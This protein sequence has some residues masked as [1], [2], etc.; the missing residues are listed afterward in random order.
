M[1]TQDI[2]TQ[3]RGGMSYH[4][5]WRKGEW[6]QREE[7]WMKQCCHWLPSQAVLF[8]FHWFFRVGRS[9]VSNTLND[10]NRRIACYFSEMCWTDLMMWRNDRIFKFILSPKQ[11]HISHNILR[12]FYH[13]NN[14]SF[15][16][17]NYV[18]RFNDRHLFS[19]NMGG[20]KVE[21]Q[22]EIVNL[23]RAEKW[24]NSVTPAHRF[25]PG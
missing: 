12:I 8:S 21:A 2:L 19:R 25:A 14:V 10:L 20:E 16:H 5:N 22:N 7:R 24:L 17:H 1:D 3:W 4:T 13:Y 6:M 23:S 9:Y 15:Y 11:L 18:S